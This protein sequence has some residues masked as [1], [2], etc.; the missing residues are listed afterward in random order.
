MLQPSSRQMPQDSLHVGYLRNAEKW[1]GFPKDP[2]THCCSGQFCYEAVRLGGW[3]TG[4]GV[5]L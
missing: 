1:S 4:L 5:G 2:Q 3:G